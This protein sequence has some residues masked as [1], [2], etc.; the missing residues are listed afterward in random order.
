MLPIRH[1]ISSL[2]IHLLEAAFRTLP[3]QKRKLLFIADLGKG[4]A[5]NPK[6]LSR[7]LGEEHSDEFHRIWV[8]DRDAT[9]SGKFPC[10]V[11]TVPFFSYRYLYHIATA[12]IVISNH[13]LPAW[14]RFK[15]RKRQRYLQTWHSSLRL[16]KIE[17]DAF[18]SGHYVETAKADSRKI[19]CLISGCRFSTDIFKRA[20]WYNG[21][22]L[23]CGTPRTDYLINSDEAER[24]RVMQAI[25]LTPE[26]KYAIYAPTFRKG[27]KLDA[28]NLVYERVCKALSKKFGGEFKLL[29]RLHPNLRGSVA[30]GNLPECCIDV[31]SH[32][33]IQELIP[34]AEVMITDFSSCMFDMAMLSK[35]CFLYASDLDEY[36]ANERGTYFSL[37]EL[38]FGIATTNDNLE[39]Q[40]LNFDSDQYGSDIAD[41]LS[42]VGSYE[43]GNACQSIYDQFLTKQLI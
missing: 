36:L 40:I 30:F 27:G 7:W 3:V 8:Y 31:T 14:F 2:A 5:C 43:T 26:F 20:F 23:E 41:F 6:Y 17:G 29:M 19:D 1:N 28:Y 15:K 35:P 9:T 10:D 32:P 18:T 13:R 12:G 25:G 16:K 21:P 39:Q 33:D 4:Y 11:T 42:K 38:P 24:Q 37:T 34:L 22:I